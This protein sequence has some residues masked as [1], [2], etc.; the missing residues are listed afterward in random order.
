[1]TN[2]SATTPTRK[3][4]TLQFGAYLGDNT[5]EIATKLT[6]YL[7][8]A[9]DVEV[10]FDDAADR[11]STSAITKAARYDIL[12]VCS[13][14]AAKFQL[15]TPELDV[16]IAAA[17]MFSGD[18]P[19]YHSVIVGS[20]GL[21][22]S[23]GD[24]DLTSVGP[25]A[26]VAINEHESWSGYLGFKRFR[27]R[28]QLAWFHN[29]IITGSHY[30]SLHAVADGSADVAAIDFTIYEY[31]A[32]REP[33]LVGSVEV[34]GET[35][36]WPSPPFLIS[37]GLEPTFAEKLKAALCSVSPGSDIA[38]EVGVAIVPA[39]VDSYREFV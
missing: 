32:R 3:P 9:L 10:I 6:P 21:S 12:W 7:T 28:Q 29:E 27:E 31:L 35:D 14:L 13:V 24:R 37:G 26:V 11:A 2:H 36:R 15:R 1:M 18:A 17:P 39:S 19:T 16:A 22:D 30:E 4:T 25:E 20:R 5:V 34:V 38:H 8:D 33:E 23:I